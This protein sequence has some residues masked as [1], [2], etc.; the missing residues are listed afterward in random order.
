MSYCVLKVDP[1]PYIVACERDTCACV[2]GGDCECLCT[3]VAAYAKACNEAGSCVSWRTPTFCRK[4][5]N[6]HNTDIADLAAVLDV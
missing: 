3:A 6:R 4:Y 5:G 2:T 1:S